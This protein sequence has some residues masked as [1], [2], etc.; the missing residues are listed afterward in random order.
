MIWDLTPFDIGI[1]DL[2]PFEIGILG[3]QDRPLY[4]PL[5]LLP[6]ALPKLLLVALPVILPAAL[7]PLRR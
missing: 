5:I 4:T 6:L 2:T 1:W 3:F 7:A